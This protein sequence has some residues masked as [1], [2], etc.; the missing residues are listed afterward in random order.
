MYR[1]SEIIIEC[2]CRKLK[3]LAIKVV[4][5]DKTFNNYIII[6]NIYYF[7]FLCLQKEE[8]IHYTHI[9]IVCNNKF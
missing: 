8:I 3:S 5:E 2:I 1:Q 7:Y 6:F 4:S 9:F